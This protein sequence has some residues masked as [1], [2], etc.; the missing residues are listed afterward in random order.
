M[1][2]AKDMPGSKSGM[3]PKALKRWWQSGKDMLGSFF[4]FLRK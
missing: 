4:G 2:Q 1:L 3:V